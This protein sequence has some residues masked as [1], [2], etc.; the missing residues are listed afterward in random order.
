MTLLMGVDSS[1]CNLGSG[2]GAYPAR[3]VQMTSMPQLVAIFNG[4][5]GATSP[6]CGS[7][8]INRA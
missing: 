8:R 7:R 4:L 2:I 6:R 5:G 1:W 3:K